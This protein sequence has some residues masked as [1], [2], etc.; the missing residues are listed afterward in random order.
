MEIKYKFI[1][2]KQVD[3]EIFAKR[4]VYRIFNNSSGD[5]I[6]VLSYY[7]QW[8]Q[9]VFSSREECVFNKSC[10]VDVLD[11]IDTAINNTKPDGGE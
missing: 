2:I 11:F 5:Q 7:S 10:L 4:P 6:G 3:D 1:T 9:Y 8:R